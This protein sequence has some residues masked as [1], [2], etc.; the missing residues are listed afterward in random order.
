MKPDDIFNLNEVELTLAQ[1]KNTDKNRL[2]FAVQL[3]YFQLE[4]RYPKHIKYIDPL[5]INCIANQLGVSSSCIDNFDWEGRSTKRFRQEVRNLLG[6]KEAGFSDIDKLKAWFIKEIF[7]N[8]V[9]RAQQIEYAYAYFRHERIEPF[10]SKELE[11]H[12]YSAHKIFEQQLFD[13]INGKLNDETKKQMDAILTDNSDTSDDEATKKNK[14][15]FK[16]LKQD[17]PGSKLK[18]VTFAIQ[19]INCL[20][21]LELPKDFLSTLSIKLVKKYFARVMAEPPS[22]I[23]ERK[24]RIRYA[25]FSLFCYLRSQLLTDGLAD[26]LIQLIHQMRTSAENFIDKKILSEVKRVNGKF[27]ILCSLAT[28]SLLNP[29]GIIQEKIYPQVKQET[30]SDLVKDLNSRGGW[31]ENQVHR[32]MHSLYSHAHRNILLTLLDAFVFKTNIH[33]SKTLLDAIQIIKVYRDS[34]ERYYPKDIVVPVENVIQGTWNNLVIVNEDGINKIHRVNYEI[35][36]LQELRKQL[37]CK[38]IWIEGALHYRNPDDDLPKDFEEKR[39]YYYGSLGLPLKVGEFIEPRKKRLHERLKL[40]NDTI[41]TNK[42]VVITSKND[43]HIKISPYEAQ[44]E[45]VNIKKLHQA[46]KQEYGTINLIDVLKETELQIKLT[47]KLNTVAS[48][49]NMPKEVLQH[50]LLLC[51]YAIGTNTGLKCMSAAN[52]HAEHSDLRYVK[53]RFINVDDVRQTIIEV[54]NKILEIRDPRVWGIA[55]TGVACDSKKISV[56]DQN[57]MVEWHARYKG[58]GV[59]VYWHVDKKALCIY[60]QLKT[61]SSS[62]VGSMIKGILDHC[63]H[64]EMNQAYVD[65]HGQSTLAFGVSELLGFELLPRLKNIHNQKLCYPSRGQK[66][67]YKNLEKILNSEIDWKLIE[68]HYDEAVK[69]IV[70]LKTGTMD[71]DVFV[72]RFNKDNYQHPV[73]KAIIEIGKVSKTNFLCRYLMEEELRIEIHEAQNVVERLNSIMGFIF[74]GKLGEISTNIKNDQEL[75]I[76]CL[77][78]LQACMAYINTIIFQNV[79]SRPEW[80]NVLTPEDNRALNVLFHSHINP[81]GL[82]PLDLNK[83]LGITTDDNQ[84]FGDIEEKEEEEEPV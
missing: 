69:H 70:A 4:D 78:L 22:S 61:C 16:H 40:L 35:A 9:K 51:L 49:E 81:Y 57:L 36:V 14:I 75:A 65:T 1:A 67:E 43:G 25:M 8:G 33:D 2:G 54:I 50:R 68:D 18:N 47:E 38:M 77:H 42:K 76:V 84:V 72:K 12:I 53:R 82:F 29:T 3:K 79:L 31:Y 41:L 71:P 55:T 17:I 60:S 13:S 7:P 30:L 34:S 26:L 52:E 66:T 56:W 44:A 80:K 27:D 20:A 39:E 46:I 15:K 74:Y 62:E 63:T 83:R 37:R 19:K 11:R 32:K 24:P 10:T 23:K 59:M 73:Y 5:M 28:I 64:M 45:P 21:E 48:R 58:R 6:Y